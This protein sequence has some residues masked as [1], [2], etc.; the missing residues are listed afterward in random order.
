MQQDAWSTFW[1]AAA[2]D[3]SL[4][5]RDNRSSAGCSVL[6]LLRDEVEKAVKAARDGKLPVGVPLVLNVAVL[7]L[8]ALRLLL[9]RCWSGSSESVAFSGRQNRNGA[10]GCVDHRARCGRASRRRERRCAHPG[11]LVPCGCLSLCVCVFWQGHEAPMCWWCVFL[12]RRRSRDVGPAVQS[13]HRR[14]AA[15]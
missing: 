10:A 6:R 9:L 8:L 13:G 11:P 1:Q 15:A 14:R 2:P 12:S 3:I 5:A 7:R 4:N